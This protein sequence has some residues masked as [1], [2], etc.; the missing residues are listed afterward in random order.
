MS[1]ASR[2]EQEKQE[3]KK[4]E[5]RVSTHSAHG[6]SFSEGSG[7]RGQ[8]VLGVR[9]ALA[10]VARFAAICVAIWQRFSQ[11]RISTF[12]LLPDL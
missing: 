8:H 10:F 2:R 1:V 9:P 3:A 11:Q 4:M 12:R 6:C 5:I 7:D